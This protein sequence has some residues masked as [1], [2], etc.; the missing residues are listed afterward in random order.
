MTTITAPAVCGRISNP[1]AKPGF[2]ASAARM[3]PRGRH[4]EVRCDLPV[5]P[6]LAEGSDTRR[7]GRAAGGLHLPGSGNCRH[8]GFEA[9][10]HEGLPCNQW[11][12]NSVEGTATGLDRTLIAF[13]M[14]QWPFVF[15]EIQG[16]I[17]AGKCSFQTALQPD[18]HW[19]R[20]EH[21]V[22]RH[23]LPPFDASLL[24]QKY[25]K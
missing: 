3:G 22:Q 20:P 17:D 23:F 18:R 2:C 16:I 5:T 9:R 8:A 1:F 7:S 6:P 11:R 13:T 15:Q 19:T 21:I 24:R 12:N 25:W 4:R 14:G 10:G